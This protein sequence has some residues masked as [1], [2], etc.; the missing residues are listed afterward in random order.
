M[1]PLDDD[2]TADRL[3]EGMGPPQPPP[4]LRERVMREAQ[5]HSAVVPLPDA[6]TRI[7]E[8][9]WLRLAWA[10]TVLLLLAG[11]LVV[12]ARQPEPPSMVAEAFVDEEIAD[13]L[14]PVRIADTVTPIIGR[15]GGGRHELIEIDQGGNAS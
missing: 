14:R 13:F 4:D 3:F 8:N 2:H 6:W 7:W 11:N 12:V 5:R 1:K 15:S 9:P 10:A